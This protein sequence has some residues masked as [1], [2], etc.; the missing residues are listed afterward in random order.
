MADR[1]RRVVWSPS[2]R[3]AL[4]DAVSYI[5]KDSLDGALRVLQET[6]DTADKLGDFSERGRLVPEFDDA[7][8]REVFVYR[9][10]L[11]YRVFADHVSV[12]TFLHGSR[13][14]GDWARRDD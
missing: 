3:Q 2:A 13:D 4:D 12:V 7:N 9:Y 14:F 8:L 6:L 5:A 11:L 1:R 10:R